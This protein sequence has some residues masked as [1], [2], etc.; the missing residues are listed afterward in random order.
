VFI[1]WENSRRLKMVNF[2][3]GIAKMVI[4]DDDIELL[5]VD[6]YATRTAEEDETAGDDGAPVMKKDDKK[7]KKRK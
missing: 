5:T 1:I 3:G 7:G 4:G 6:G 2:F